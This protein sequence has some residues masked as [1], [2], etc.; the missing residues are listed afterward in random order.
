MTSVSVKE[1]RF[2]RG[3]LVQYASCDFVRENTA[4][5]SSAGTVMTKIIHAGMRKVKPPQW[6]KCFGMDDYAIA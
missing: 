3:G 4:I 2:A 1:N 6:A 5:L